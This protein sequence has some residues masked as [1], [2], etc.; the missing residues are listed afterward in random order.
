MDIRNIRCFIPIG[1]QGTRLRPLTYDVSKP[2]I[3]FLNRP[4]IEFSI[5]E[6]AEQGIRNFIFGELGYTNYANLFDQY[7]EGVG[8]SAKYNIEPRLHIKHQPNIDDLGSA[9][10]FWINKEYYDIQDPILVVQGDNLFKLNL[11]GLVK[12]HERRKALMSIGLIKVENTEQYG[13]AKLGEDMQIKT[14]IEK[15]RKGEAPSNFANAGIYLISPNIN[16]VLLKDDLKKIMSERNRLDFGYDFIPYLVD[17]GYP[18]YGYPVDVWYDVGNIEHYLQA[19]L[20]ILHG[21]LDIRV[22]EK[23]ILSGRNLWVQGFSQESIKR[24]QEILNKYSEKRLFLDGAALIGRHT[25][26]GDYSK[27]SESCVDNFCILGEH[28]YIDRSAVLDGCRIGDYA[29]ITDSIVGRKTIIESSLEHPTYIEGNSALGSSVRIKE[30]CR[31]IRTKINPGLVI[32]K[33]MTYV[34]KTLLTFEDVVQ[35]SS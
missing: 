18:V 12:E 14:F 1:G 5:I 17:H 3:R 32:P 30:G 20:E 2:C 9:H 10:S 4:L 28:V 26:I 22:A 13:V 21:K 19:M 29:N 11:A 27:I 25:R 24:R 15:P 7:A 31:L 8:V 23:R 6:L 16:D 35:L 33:G 34:D